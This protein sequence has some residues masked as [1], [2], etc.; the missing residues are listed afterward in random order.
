MPELPYTHEERQYLAKLLVRE[1]AEQVSGTKL[2]P[3]PATKRPRSRTQ[4]MRRVIQL[5][6]DH[7]LLDSKTGMQAL[8]ARQFGVSPQAVS[9][10]VRQVRRNGTDLHLPR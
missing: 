10:Q 9:H 5:A 4:Q 3:P 8:I 6:M 1:F 2:I 7:G